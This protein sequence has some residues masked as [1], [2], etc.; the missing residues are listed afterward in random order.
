MK[1][2]AGL[3]SLAAVQAAEPL[4]DFMEKQFNKHVKTYSDGFSVDLEPYLNLEVSNNGLSGKMVHSFSGGEKDID[5]WEI[6]ESDDGATVVT[7]TGVTHASNMLMMGFEAFEHVHHVNYE[8]V[9]E[10]SVSPAGLSVDMSKDLDFALKNKKAG[11][12]DENASLKVDF[13]QSGSSAKIDFDISADRRSN[14][15]D[16]LSGLKA[17][18]FIAPYTADI[19]AEV[20]VSDTK[21]CSSMDKYAQGCNLQFEIEATL[22]QKKFCPG[23]FYECQAIRRRLQDSIRQQK[24]FGLC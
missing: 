13:T 5:S 11:S 8:Q 16:S 20:S 4:S 24:A 21:K 22:D 3:A 14:G 6:T 23:F 18:Y 12:V 2:L 17:Y 15:L 19:N 7:L 9:W 1:Y 10:F